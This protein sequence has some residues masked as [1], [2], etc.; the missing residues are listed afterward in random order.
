M[1]NCFGWIR[2]GNLGT[3]NYAHPVFHAIND[4]ENT[5]RVGSIAR[6]YI[7]LFNRRTIDSQIFNNAH[8]ALEVGLR[9]TAFDTSAFWRYNAPLSFVVYHD[10][11]RICRERD[12]RDFAHTPCMS[13]ELIDRLDYERFPRMF[14]PSAQEA[15]NHIRNIYNF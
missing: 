11:V 13:Q 14:F 3:S 10:S 12:F 8:Q 5:I 15:E 9:M 4:P 6:G 1:F 7:C 2:G